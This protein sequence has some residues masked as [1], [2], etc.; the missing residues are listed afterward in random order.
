MPIIIIKLAIIH[1]II[2]RGI[3]NGITLVQKLNNI[4]LCFNPVKML[5]K[6]L[7]DNRI[8]VYQTIRAIKSF[9]KNLQVF[10]IYVINNND[11]KNE[12]TM[13]LNTCQ[14]AMDNFM[15][16]EF[17]DKKPDDWSNVDLLQFIKYEVYRIKLHDRNNVKLISSEILFEF[18][19][20]VNYRTSIHRFKYVSISKHH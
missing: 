17:I 15:Q 11:R 16:F 5:R 10:N 12:K 2:L 1:V 3:N 8:S 13:E 6:F 20:K 7:N 9:S 14:N 19:K 18:E 4:L